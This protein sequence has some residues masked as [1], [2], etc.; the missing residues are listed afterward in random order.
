MWR[1]AALGLRLP[2]S[3]GRFTGETNSPG[4]S[5]IAT[6]QL[7]LIHTFTKIYAKTYS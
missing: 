1:R 5:E 2:S 4:E 3:L 7:R 6:C